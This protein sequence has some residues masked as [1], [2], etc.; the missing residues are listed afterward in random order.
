MYT[1][2]ELLASLPT[3]QYDDTIFFKDENYD[4]WSV[5]VEENWDEDNDESF[6]WAT[7]QHW[8]KCYHYAQ[9][10]GQSIPE[11]II[12]CLVELELIPA[13]EVVS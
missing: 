5:V 11:A 8:D 2:P 4:K 10:V 6:P 9:N 13:G 1:I 3:I 12:N 7:V